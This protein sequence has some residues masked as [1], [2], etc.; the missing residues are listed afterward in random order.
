MKIGA[1]TPS[2]EKMVKARTT[3]RV[4]RA[5]KRAVNPTYGIKGKDF[6][7]DPERAVKNKIY[8][9]LTVDPLD[10]AKHPHCK[11]AAPTEISGEEAPAHFHLYSLFVLAEVLCLIVFLYRIIAY[12]EAHVIWM[13]GVFICFIIFFILRKFDI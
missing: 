12:R 5:A 3:G 2:P 9:E 13:L 10:P 8:H 4:K 1:R 6:L 11:P 7:T